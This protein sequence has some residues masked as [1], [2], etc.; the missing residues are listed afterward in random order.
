MSG[1]AG[2]VERVSTLELF[3]DLVFVFTITQLTDRLVH[4]LDWAGLAQVVV[5]LGVIWWMYGGYAWLTNA[6]AADRAGRRLLLLGGMA[7]YLVLALAI[8]D[9]FGSAGA[10]FGIAYVVI[11]AAHGALFTRAS[12]EGVLHS[13]ITLAP[14]NGV[15]ALL[16]LAGGIAGGGAQYALWAAAVAVQWIT[17]R[18]IDDSGFLIGAAH[19]VE[20]HGLVVIVAIGGSRSS[21]SASAPRASTSNLALTAV[22]VLGLRSAPACG[23]HFGGDDARADRPSAAAP[24][25]SATAWRSTRSS[26]STSPCCSASCCWRRA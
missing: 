8:P 21:P 16:V 14:Y 25:S 17:P 15:S 7:G 3:F 26:T 1:P 11:V 6:V 12:R 9:A 20:R 18:L 2:E 5:M 13:V 24:A 22:A 23:G 19:F 4:H 10:A